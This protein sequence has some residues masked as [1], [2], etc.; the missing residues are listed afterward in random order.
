MKFKSSRYHLSVTMSDLLQPPVT[1]S[2]SCQAN[3]SGSSCERG[4]AQRAASA[5]SRRIFS[6]TVPHNWQLIFRH[7]E[8]ADDHLQH[9]IRATEVQ[10]CK[11][12][13]Q[14][15]CDTVSLSPSSN[16][17]IRMVLSRQN[18][19]QLFNGGNGWFSLFKNLLM[20]NN[21][22]FRMNAESSC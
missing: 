21:W 19:R 13:V 15:E 3:T 11:E 4:R 14:R 22:R 2:R 6:C 9:S 1:E 7:A 18:E 17:V 16:G 5:L 8:A 10:G 12:T 20:R